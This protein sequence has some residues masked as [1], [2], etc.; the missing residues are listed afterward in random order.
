[1]HDGKWYLYWGPLPALLQALAKSLLGISKLIGDQYLVLGFSLLSAL[2]GALLIED[3]RQRMFSSVPRWLSALC[4]FA[5]AFANPV[6]YLVATGGQYQAAIAGGQTGLLAGMWCAFRAVEGSASES[7][8]R[9]WLFWSGCG[10]AAALACRISVGAA[11]VLLAACSI[12]FAARSSE[13]RW[14]ALLPNAFYMGIAPVLTG[15]CLLLYN[16]LRFGS[17]LE[18]GV[19]EQVSYFEFKLSTRYLL[20]NLYS[21]ALLPWGFSCRFPFALQSFS[22]G[23][24]GLPPWLPTPSGYLVL[25][26]ISGFLSTAPISW[27]SPVPLLV[28]ASH[29][30]ELR[31]RAWRSYTFVTLCFAV[32]GGISGVVVLFVYGAT[33]RYLDE[34]I[35]GVVLLGVLGAFTW[36]ATRVTPYGRSFVAVVSAGLCSATIVLGL[37][38][39]YQG[40]GDHFLHN[41]P[42]LHE[43]LVKHLSVCGRK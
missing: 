23:P 28:A 41:N 14:K 42:P 3:I 11:A 1:L 32:T 34:F 21:Y 2:F 7:G 37:L 29:L 19:K 20:A 24:K 9:F 36:Y 25:E 31:R 17:W 40:Y 38:L 27:L 5:L 43:K 33:M 8:R 12:A 18:F 26:P 4:I 30:R 35:Y 6:I 10:L 15:G 39:G 22:G 16:E 13:A